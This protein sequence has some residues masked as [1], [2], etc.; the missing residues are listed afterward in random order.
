MKNINKI[1][2]AAII[3]ALYVVLTFIANALGLASGAVQ[4]RISE[5]LTV[6]PIFTFSAV[7]GLAVGCLVANLLTG[8][9]LWD[10]VFGTVAT[11]IGALGTYMLRKHKFLALIPP[12]VSNA[13]IVPFVL[14]YAYGVKDALPFLMLTVGLGEIISVGVLG[15]ALLKMLDKNSRFLFKK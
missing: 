5:A 12:V 4:V 1:T 6:L 11:L 9:V 14:I 3:A 8:C 7:P 15:G 10:T 2:T 13:V